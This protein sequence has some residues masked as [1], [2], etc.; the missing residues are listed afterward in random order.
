MPRVSP[1]LPVPPHR[2]LCQ[3]VHAEAVVAGHER[4][5]QG[6]IGIGGAGRIDGL[7][8]VIAPRRIPAQYANPSISSE[9]RRSMPAGWSTFRK[10]PCPLLCPV[11]RVGGKGQVV[12]CLPRPRPA[13]FRC[14]CVSPSSIT[15][16]TVCALRSITT[17]PL[18]PGEGDAVAGKG[19]RLGGSEGVGDPRCAAPAFAHRVCMSV[20]F[21]CFGF[22]AKVMTG[23]SGAMSMH[24]RLRRRSASARGSRVFTGVALVRVTLR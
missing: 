4:D 12:G 13:R 21:P 22:S 24:C 15:T 11:M 5:G 23:F 19:N 2:R 3:V 9:T 16:R 14:R 8:A 1:L 17:P 18:R 10:Q 7:A 6:G 20:I